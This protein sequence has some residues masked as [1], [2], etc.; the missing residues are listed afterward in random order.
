MTIFKYLYNIFDKIKNNFKKYKI[1]INEKLID[2][3]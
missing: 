1:N 3:I 2:L